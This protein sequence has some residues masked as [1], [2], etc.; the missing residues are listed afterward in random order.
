MLYGDFTRDTSRA[1]M[2]SCVELRAMVL[3]GS[4]ATPSRRLPYRLA[5]AIFEHAWRNG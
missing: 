1:G 4:C 3:L 2:P 5:H